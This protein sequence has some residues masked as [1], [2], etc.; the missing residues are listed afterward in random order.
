MHVGIGPIL[1]FSPLPPILRS[2]GPIPFSPKEMISSSR[3]ALRSAARLSG[4]RSLATD[5]AK[6]RPPLDLHG[7]HAR[8]ANATYTAASKAGSLAQ[9]E[10]DLVSIQSIAS[11][12]VPFAQ[13][14]ENP[15]I[16]RGNKE[17]QVEDMIG[18][19]VAPVTLNLMKT[20]AGNARLN[21]VS[22]IVD[23]YVELMKASRG[24]VEATI[25]SADPLTK[26]QADA[27]ATA[28]KTQVGEGKKVVLSTQVDP[29]IVGGL[30]I[31]IGDQFLDLSVR[32]RI[33][34]IA[35]TPV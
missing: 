30:Q 28:M 27:I 4:G 20:L 12:S 5:A 1:T 19:K 7:I 18:A 8:Y 9:V 35:R 21:E 15:L 29:S 24:E 13:F 14:L 10:Q 26:T 23:M 17:A 22:K 16:S 32:S 31:Q 25:V 11:T 2:A 6:H 34:A 33:D 3:L